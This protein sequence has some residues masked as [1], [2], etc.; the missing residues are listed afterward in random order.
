MAKEETEMTETEIV[1][2]GLGFGIGMIIHMLYMDLMY[3]KPHRNKY[4]NR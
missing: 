1:W 4:D 3:R 2:F